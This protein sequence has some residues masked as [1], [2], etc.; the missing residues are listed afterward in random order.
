MPLTAT[1][2]LGVRSLRSPMGVPAG[3]CDHRRAMA[4]HPGV[5]RHLR[6]S[7]DRVVAGVCGGLGA[8]LGVD[9]MVLRLAFVVL[10]LAN[11]VGLLAYAA[12]WALLPE[13]PSGADIPR[14][15]HQLSADKTIALGL[16]TLG[17]LLLVREIGLVVPPEVVWPVTLSLV[18]FGMV[19][20]RTSDAGR[21]RWLDL[22]RGRAPNGAEPSEQA[23]RGRVVVFRA[24]TGGALLVTGLALL[25]ASG[26]FLSTVGQLGLAMLAT[27]VGVA[28]LLGPWIVTLWRGREEERR[29]RIRSEERSEMAA[30]LH[31]SVLQTL[32]LVQR[33]A[34][35]PARARMLA[36]RQEREL[37]AWLFDERAPMDGRPDAL[38]PALEAV[39]T[40]V[41]DRHVVE[42]DLVVVGDCPL[43]RGLE[44]LVA[45][46]REAASNA[47]RHA[48]AEEVSV[49]VEVE[50]DRVTAYVRDRGRGFDLDAVEPG[51]LGVRESIIGR[52][53]RL[54]GRAEVHTAPGEG[55]EVVL[56]VA[57]ARAAEETRP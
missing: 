10:T 55:T 17:V 9:P 12:A 15:R 13:A 38:L 27:G 33:H 19:W 45:A 53:A 23:R 46:V 51:R 11:G 7:D 18:G 42:V 30:H 20:A 34:E 26:G 8:H 40:E 22:A 2:R 47:A 31:D 28:L 43:D 44:G 56:E 57:R 41:E 36:R 5:Q 39:V 35:S 54:G 37:R 21:E 4:H 6:S 3:P 1:D 29:Q 14:G 24:V 25:F 32:T 48:G 49:Y 50:P 16:I 52:M